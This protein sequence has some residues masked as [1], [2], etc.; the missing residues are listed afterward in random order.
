[1]THQPWLCLAGNDGNVKV[2]DVKQGKL[3]K[4]FPKLTILSISA[5]LT[6]IIRHSLA[7]AA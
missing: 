4:V 7:M 2:Y 3:V 1:M 6:P 5:E